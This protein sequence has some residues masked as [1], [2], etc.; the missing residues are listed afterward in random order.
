ML[1]GKPE[2]NVTCEFCASRCETKRGAARK[3][4]RLWPHS[5]RPEAVNYLCIRC[6][7]RGTFSAPTAQE[8]TEQSAEEKAE[9]DRR[10]AE[11][12]R[13]EEKAKARRLA[14]A[15]R[16]W[17][18][19]VDPVGTWAEEYLN[20][21]GI[22]LPVNGYIRR[23]AFGFHPECPFPDCKPRPALLVAFTR[24]MRN[25]ALDVFEDDEVV[26]I[27]RITG[28]GHDNK[29]MLGAVGGAAMMI[30]PREQV[31]G[32]LHIAE[33][34]ETALAIYGEGKPV[35]SFRE[36]D[37]GNPLAVWQRP[38]WALGSAG[39]IEAFPVIPRVRKL[40]IWA[41]HDKS[42]TGIEAARR[43]AERW[44]D[45]GRSVEILMPT[46]EGADYAQ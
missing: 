10:F 12:R 18:E 15:R 14:L 7:E 19:A 23:L 44:K 2:A 39:A 25:P 38:I 4:L 30:S 8:K 22:Q 45:A 29:A 33:G 42:R 1:D 40:V 36:E 31:G 28:R 3:V 17:R 34:V 24:I 32:V 41:D 6:G 46:R 26:A 27:H 37:D 20:G 21:R 9:V 16:L 35:T 11:K 5:K 43:C 13:K